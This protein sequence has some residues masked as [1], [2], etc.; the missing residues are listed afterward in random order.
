MTA[1]DA[2]PIAMKIH[3]MMVSQAGMTLPVSFRRTVCGAE[4]GIGSSLRPG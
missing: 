2:T 1:A 3:E 4:A